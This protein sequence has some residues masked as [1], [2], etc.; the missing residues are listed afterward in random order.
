MAQGLMLVFSSLLAMVR[1]AGS[2]GSATARSRSG[3]EETPDSDPRTPRWIREGSSDARSP[4]ATIRTKGDLSKCEERPLP[5]DLRQWSECGP[6]QDQVLYNFSK[7]E[8]T[9]PG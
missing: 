1:H 8:G 4:A 7:R 6:V 5:I 3:P 2:Q 9:V